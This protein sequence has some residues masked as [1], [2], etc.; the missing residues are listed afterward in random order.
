MSDDLFDRANAAIDCREV[1][2]KAVALKQAGATWRGV[3]PLRGCGSK[4]KSQP[5]A[6]FAAGARWRCMSCDPKGGDAVDLEHR[7]FAT[8]GETMADTARRL[9]GGVSVEES[10][11]SRRR[12]QEAREKAEAEALAD[13]AWKAELA[14][15]LWREAK[16]AAGTPVQVYLE[17]RAIRGPI[18][19]AMLGQLRFHPA[20]Y[21]SGDPAH[22]VRL[23][24]MVGLV[25]TELGP[26]GGVHVTYL[27]PDGRGKTHR[28]PAKRMW[29]PQGHRLL[30]RKGDRMGPPDRRDDN[31]LADILLPGGIWLTR[32]DA[33]GPLAVAEGIES[34]AS[35]AI[36]MAG[37]LHRSVRAV[38][39]GSLDRLQGFE[40]VET[41]GEGRQRISVVDVAKPRGDVLRPPF[42]WPEDPRAPWG[43]VDIA[44]DSDMSPVT[45]VG[46]TG[47]NRTGKRRAAPYRRDAVERA[48][49]CGTLATSAWRRRLAPGSATTVRMS[50]PPAGLDFNDVVRAAEAARETEAAKAAGGV[51]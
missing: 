23:P 38:A 9:I 2:E 27:R 6:V 1:A 36:L 21:H 50:K 13:A 35:R 16:A 47:A 19:A 25:M 30:A 3:C 51:A 45:V 46:L 33:P 43:V 14:A 11:G 24:A 31:D 12:R 15:R 18:A 48:R 37:D 29:G 5:F 20:A 22:G 10:E 40:A 34:A 42:T 44:C 8:G 41:F 7:L 17:H 28:E 26:T 39:A 32:P 4:S 49:V